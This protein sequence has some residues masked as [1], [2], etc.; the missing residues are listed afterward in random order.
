MEDVKD[1]S[2]FQLM[3]EH[4]TKERKSL[5]K[6][7]KQLEDTLDLYK[8]YQDFIQKVNVDYCQKSFQLYQDNPLFQEF[9][10]YYLV[11]KNKDVSS[12]EKWKA[13]RKENTVDPNRYESEKMKLD[14][15]EHQLAL[16]NEEL[17]QLH[18]D[19]NQKTITLQKYQDYQNYVASNQFPFEDSSTQTFFDEMKDWQE[20]KHNES[21]LKEKSELYEEGIEQYKGFKLTKIVSIVF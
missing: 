11:P 15:T 4:W 13:F 8:N 14:A 10:C 17:L 7:K 16:K 9:A 6:K 3:K 2:Q 21:R 19:P 18:Y 5:L 1:S 12:H 20:L